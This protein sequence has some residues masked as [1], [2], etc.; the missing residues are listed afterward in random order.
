MVE[1]GLCFPKLNSTK[2]SPVAV[3]TVTLFTE[4][5][6]AAVVAR[7][8]ESIGN[9]RCFDYIDCSGGLYHCFSSLFSPLYLYQTRVLILSIAHL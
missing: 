7:E 5:K 6:A 1:E 8:N 4:F 3:L 2:D 9:R